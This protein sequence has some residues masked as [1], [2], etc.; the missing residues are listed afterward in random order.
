MSGSRRAL[1]DRLESLLPSL[2]PLLVERAS[3]EEKEEE[4]REESE[5]SEMSEGEAAA[6]L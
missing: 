4:E 3:E 2:S 5:E 1:Q 6:M